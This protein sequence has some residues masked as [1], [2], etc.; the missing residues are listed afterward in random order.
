[1]D[2][3]TWGAIKWLGFILIS[4]SRMSRSD[5]RLASPNKS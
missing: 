4:Q 1:M 3:E 5:S 2:K